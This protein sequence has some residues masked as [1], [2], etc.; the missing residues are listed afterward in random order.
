MNQNVCICF[1]WRIILCFVDI[2][3]KPEVCLFVLRKR[4]KKK[5]RK[6]EREMEGKG[7]H[8]YVQYG[9]VLLVSIRGN[10]I[11]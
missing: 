10:R 3:F 5:E 2:Y 7:R 1:L 8:Q 9:Y 4:K 11:F 6:K